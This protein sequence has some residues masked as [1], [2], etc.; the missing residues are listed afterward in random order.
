MLDI[1]RGGAEI[2]MTGQNL[3][4]AEGAARL[5]DLP[6]RSRDEGSPPAMRG[7][8][9]HPEPGVQP[10]KPYSDRPGRQTAVPLAVDDRAV[11]TSLV[12]SLFMESYERCLNLRVHRNDAAP[13]FSF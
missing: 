9:D 10:V 3:D 6:G 2:G 7:A 1:S 11:W 13:A 4:I 8:A 12:A 5:A